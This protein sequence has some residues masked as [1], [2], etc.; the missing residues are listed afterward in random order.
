MS[1]KLV[2]ETLQSITNN[3]KTLAPDDILSA[4]EIAKEVGIQRNTTSQYLNELVKEGLAIKVK[5]RPAMFY[6][7]QVFAELFFEPIKSVYE[8]YDALIQEKKEKTM[9]S[10]V[11]DEVIGDKESLDKVIDQIKAATFYPGTGLPIML[12]GDT[13]VGKSLLA[14]KLYEFCVEQGI[15]AQNAPYLELNCAQYYHNP[16]LMSSIL[17]G[18]KKGAFTGADDNH[19]GLLEAADGGVLFLDE[20]HRLSPE[21]QEKL[22]H[23][24]DHHTFSR[25]GQNEK[26]IKSH[27]RLVFATTET[28]QENFLRT[29]IRRIPI[30]AHIPTLQERTKHEIAE[31]VYTFF[32][33]ESRKL[34]CTIVVSPWIMNRL[35]TMVYRDNVGELKNLIKII[36]AGAFSKKI[37]ANELTI[38]AESLENNLLA[39]FLALKEIDNIEDQDVK[40]TPLNETKDFIRTDNQDNRLIM[41][42]F[43]VVARIFQQFES[44][45]ISSD[46][47]INQLSREA[48]TVI[49]MFVYD[50]AEEKASLKLL[51]N[52]VKELINFLESSFFIKIHGNSIIA[53]TSYLYKRNQL[54]IDQNFVSQEELL[55]I[56]KF[57]SD[58]LMRESKLLNALLALVESKLDVT[59]T[60]TEK[61][62][63]ILY[64]RGLNLEVKSPKTRCVI[65][66]HGFSTASSIADVVNRFL[67]EHLFDAFDMPFNVPLE[68]VKDFMN[69][70]LSV[71]DCSNGLIVLVDMGSLLVLAENL[72]DQLSGPMLIMNNVITQQA[73]FIGELVKKKNDLEIIAEKIKDGM[74]LEYRVVYPNN[75]RKPMIITVCHTGMGAAQQLKAFL[76]SSIPKETGYE[77]EA[78]DFHYL[79]KYGEQTT[80]FKQY[81]VQGI[82]GTENPNIESVPY[83][84]LEDLI[85]G[86]GKERIDQIFKEIRDSDTRKMINDN[87]VRNLSIERLISAVTILDVKKVIEYIDEVIIELE[88]RLKVTLTNSK[89][90]ILYVHIAGL[91]E[92][93]IRNQ[94]ATT[95]EMRELTRE[96]EYKM[97][98]ISDAIS[99]LETAYNIV[100]SKSEIQYIYDIIYI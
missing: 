43:K 9:E 58:H 47:V 4:E 7:R 74:P 55:F 12:Q 17:F 33:Q 30:I 83:V 10:K 98:L 8:S 37:N 60:A 34:N 97:S 77:I 96:E 71:N 19:I 64:L 68:K 90:A 72:K 46:Y 66:A 88:R 18:Y 50:D 28:V 73:L 81:A 100:V 59:L 32:I 69:H 21:S 42:F 52:T 27:V 56:Q 89:K 54:T 84:S 75:K 29:F 2:I 11:F 63:L 99:I 3:V 85:S 70:Y 5:T 80:L 14:R 61:I 51:R 94:D 16:E 36:C 35:L 79:K 20:C 25:I 62:L 6:D 86:Q 49:E 91:V 78:V 45:E 1:K 57:I 26:T 40:I 23:Y 48:T 22:F 82:V 38:T 53:L 67:D 41:D 39:K 87:L 95:Y 93:I 31:Y 76:Q 44:N 15:L 13:G 92:R 24:I 65:L